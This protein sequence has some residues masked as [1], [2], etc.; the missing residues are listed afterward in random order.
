MV[1]MTNILEYWA[2]YGP[3]AA[4]TLLIGFVVHNRLQRLQHPNT[5]GGSDVKRGNDGSS[6]YVS[7]LRKNKGTLAASRVHSREKENV[8]SPDRRHVE[9]S[10]VEVDDPAQLLDSQGQILSTATLAAM[11]QPT[12]HLKY[13]NHS[14]SIVT[15]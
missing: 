11:K 9:F 2:T 15:F 6:V 13:R 10:D 3:I 7:P 5:A 12:I 4:A 14:I 1:D 8:T